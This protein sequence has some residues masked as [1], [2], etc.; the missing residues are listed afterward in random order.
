MHHATRL[1]TTP[2]VADLAISKD[3]SS[4]WQVRAK[5]PEQQFED[6]ME[7]ARNHAAEIGLRA[8]RAPGEMLAKMEENPGG[9]PPKTGNNVFPV[10]SLSGLGIRKMHSGRP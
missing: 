3:Q 2:T 9:R 5:V 10:S 6:W 8:E 7:D 1:I 4:R